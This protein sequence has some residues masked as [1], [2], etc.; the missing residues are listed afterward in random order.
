[1][2]KMAQDSDDD[3]VFIK[4]V[5]HFN[6]TISVLVDLTKEDEGCVSITSIHQK[7]EL[8]SEIKQ[9]EEEESSDPVPTTKKNI[10][11]REPPKCQVNV[12]N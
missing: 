1:M 6:G 12:L 4:E 11:Y 7:Q 5:V 8:K 9:E 10:W 3:N 2:I